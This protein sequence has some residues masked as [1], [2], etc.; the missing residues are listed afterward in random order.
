MLSQ[1]FAIATRSVP[2]MMQSENF[3]NYH[4]IFVRNAFGNY[5]EVMHEIA[6]SAMMGESL[7]YVGS[8]SHAFVRRSLNVISHADEN[9][10]REIM[11]LFTIG[12]VLLNEDGTL[13]RDKNGNEIAAYSNEV[14]TSGALLCQSKQHAGLF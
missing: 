9:F 11:Q 7:S 13:K 2:N 6:F 4:D 14:S 1:I 5:R 3:V 10:A 8:K 12:T